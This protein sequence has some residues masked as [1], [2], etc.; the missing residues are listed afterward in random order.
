MLYKSFCLDFCVLSSFLYHVKGD[1][2]TFFFLLE[3]HVRGKHE[4]I[5]DC[6]N[7]FVFLWFLPLYLHTYNKILYS[8]RYII[9]IIT[10]KEIKFD[11]SRDVFKTQTMERNVW[12]DLSYQNAE[13]G[14]IFCK[15]KDMLCSLLVFLYIS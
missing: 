10:K 7:C 12:C 9:K 2:S 3:P 5:T 14:F 11:R 6:C 4:C 8:Y 15:W 13:H 1:L